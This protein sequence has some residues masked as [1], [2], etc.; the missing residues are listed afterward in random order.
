M[1]E[2]KTGTTGKKLK[3]G[4]M[5]GC[6]TPVI[7]IALSGAAWFIFKSL[8]K[9]RK[10]PYI[11]KTEKQVAHRQKKLLLQP[12]KEYD[13]DQTIQAIY[14]IEKALREANTFE[15]LSKLILQKQSDLVASDAAELKYRFF[16]IYKDLLREQDSL[17][18]LQ[19]MYGIVGGA[20][21]DVASLV[22]VSGAGI[23]YD[24]KQAEKVWEE[25]LSRAELE[26]DIKQRLYHNQDRL[27]K[28]YFDF[29][30]VRGKYIKEWNRLCALR[31][32]AYIAVFENKPGEAIKNAA[33]ATVLAPNEKEA[34]L[35]LAMCLLERG[36]ETDIAQAESII[37]QYLDK[38]QGQEAPAYLLRGVIRL[39]QK[40]YDAAVI[41]FDQAATYYP[42][43]QE[44]LL[45]RLNLY[46]RRSFLNKSKEGRMIINMYRGIMTGSG[47]FSP[48]FQLA[49]IYLDRNDLNRGKTK[50]FDHFFRRRNQGQWDKVLDDFRFCSRY[51]DSDT[52]T[53]IGDDKL[54]LEI[55]P[56]FFF[57][58]VIV[59]ITNNSK[60]D[61]HNVSL[62]LCVRFT[63]MFKGDYVTFPVGETIAN[64]KAGES[65][66][67][68]RR[69]ISDV[70]KEKLNS[71]KEFKDIIQCA[72]VMISDESINWVM[73]NK[74]VSPTKNA[75]EK[76]VDRT[77]EISSKLN[78][79]VDRAMD[80]AIDKAD[81]LM[82]KA[83]DKTIDKVSDTIEKK[84]DAAVSAK[85]K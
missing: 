56:A 79:K 15:D 25:R 30:R 32:R 11:I 45:D 2:E 41:D 66:E 51:L 24:R 35:L 64:L 54:K 39:K 84:I 6:L 55:E 72:A 81:K 85:D 4:L 7:L 53:A 23:T 1:Q 26:R 27:L 18:E 80:K 78:G 67:F 29:M 33:A 59:K 50:I 12:Q 40:K 52:F 44:V 63:N 73:V 69:H 71:E 14:S 28:F 21:L 68:G 37:N 5:I 60:R 19:S 75:P 16:N 34:H 61:I 58:K 76:K 42:K 17:A 77:G 83:I 74:V 10:P 82:D 9:P 43:Q 70:T 38:H 20:V 22:D 62:L 47:Y 48:D 3:K 46:R 49:R 13:I 8:E 57:N 31:D 65:I 36:E